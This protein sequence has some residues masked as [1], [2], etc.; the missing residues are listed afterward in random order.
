MYYA[1]LKAVH[2]LGTVYL[3]FFLMVEFLRSGIVSINDQVLLILA[4][5]A[6]MKRMRN[7]YH[8]LLFM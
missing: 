4:E 1:S 3:V 6:K 7:T 2:H 8:V 5:Y